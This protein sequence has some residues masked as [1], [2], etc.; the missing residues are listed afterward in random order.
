M[1]TH[2]N[3]KPYTTHTLLFREE[4]DTLPLGLLKSNIGHTEGASG[5]AAIIKVLLSYENESIP[6]NINIKTIKHECKQYIPPLYPN[7]EI[8]KYEPGKY[9]NIDSNFVF[10]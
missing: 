9:L 10:T 8:L 4:R 3:L 7:T 1:E 5:I 2:K 6:P